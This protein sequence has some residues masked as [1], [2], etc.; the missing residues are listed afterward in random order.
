MIPVARDAYLFL[1]PLL[2][3][4]GA[5]FIL[6]LPGWGLVPLVLAV[7]VGLFFRDPERRVPQGPGLVVA[8]A[9]G[10]VVAVRQGVGADGEGPGS[11]S[12]VSIFLSVLDVH[13]NRAPC[14]GKVTD[15]AYRPGRFLVAW[16][17]EASRVNEQAVIALATANGPVTVKQI[18]GILARRVVTWIRP[19]QELKAGERI[20]LIRFGSRV[21]LLVPQ[22]VALA[23]KVGDRVRGGETVVGVFQ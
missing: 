4:A 8:P 19:G 5:L 11:F 2:G 22:R 23:V 12:Q 10:R 9:D 21:D 1:I 18:A 13:V 3:I 15:F 20:G 7:G 17:D 16:R 14:E 6:R